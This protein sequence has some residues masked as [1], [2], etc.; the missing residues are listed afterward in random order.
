LLNLTDRFLDAGMRT[1]FAQAQVV[2]V[3][4]KKRE[5]RA[6]VTLAAVAAAGSAVIP[7]PGGHGVALAVIQVG[8]MAKI[9][10]IFGR[11]LLGGKN[12]IQGA[13]TKLAGMSGRWA[14]GLALETA[15]KFIP[16]AGSIAG[17]AI[18]GGVGS[19][20]TTTMGVAYVEVSA[21]V[22]AGDPTLSNA[23]AILD[24]LLAEFLKKKSAA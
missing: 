1:A 19:A 18:G 20:I 5:A 8:M 10:L 6:I 14:F 4:L 17:T 9:D 15:L 24:A 11:S 12:M 7:V 22:A 13:A 16:G 21:R 23:A 2:N 3:E